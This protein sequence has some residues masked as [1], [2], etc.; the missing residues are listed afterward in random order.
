MLCSTS[1][2]LVFV[3]NLYHKY[4]YYFSHSE[5]PTRAVGNP[6]DYQ[7][8][9]GKWRSKQ[10]KLQCESCFISKL[11]KCLTVSN[12]SKMNKRFVHFHLV[13]RTIAHYLLHLALREFL[14]WSARKSVPVWNLSSSSRISNLIDLWFFILLNMALPFEKENATCNQHSFCLHCTMSEILQEHLS[15]SRCPTY[16]QIN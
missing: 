3:K 11:L 13:F 12:L 8:W 6:P 7:K 4:A 2:H 1:L 15:S 9:P 10:G 5:W 14:V 16:H